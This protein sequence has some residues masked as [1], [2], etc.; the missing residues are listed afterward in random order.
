MVSVGV[1]QDAL[2]FSGP[3]CY[4]KNFKVQFGRCPAR[5]IFHDALQMFLQLQDELEKFVEIWQGLDDVPKA[6]ELFDKGQIGKVAFKL[7]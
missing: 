3:E 1:Q 7:S 5:G 2:P 4:A 6:Y